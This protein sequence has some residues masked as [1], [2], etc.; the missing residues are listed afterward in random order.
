M[1]TLLCGPSG[2][3]KSVCLRERIAAAAAAGRRVCLLVPE[4]EA[5]TREREIIAAIPPSAQ[6]SVE[7]F[8]FS[9]LANHAFRCFG[10]ISYRSVTPGARALS[11]WQTL[12]ALSPFL[13]EYGGVQSESALTSLMRGAVSECKA[14]GITPQ[15]L[16]EVSATLP[17]GSVLARKLSDLAL[18]LGGY[19]SRIAANYDDGEDDLARLAS[20]LAEHTLFA[21]TEVFVDSFTSFTAVELEVL[22][23]VCR[24]ATAMTV[25]LCCDV[26]TGHGCI[27]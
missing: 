20:L 4:Q 26:P 23:H 3:G 5:V 15:R 13:S 2:S 8:N 11:M 6:L 17:E 9:R 19:T 24:Q 22:Q 1:I 18:I 16:E 12:R 10:G 21:D 25:A 27:F 14:Y 7:V